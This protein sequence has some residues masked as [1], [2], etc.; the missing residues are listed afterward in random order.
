[1]EYCSIKEAARRIGINRVTL[2]RS[3]I[4][5][6]LVKVETIADRPAISADEIE[7]IKAIRAQKAGGGN[8]K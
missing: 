6:G 1:M 7:R 3:W 5:R 2:Y 4:N 8:D